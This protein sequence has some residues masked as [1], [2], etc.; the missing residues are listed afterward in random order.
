M[1]PI[2]QMVVVEKRKTYWPHILG[3]ALLWSL[4]MTMD[5]ADQAAQAEERAQD[6]SR[7]MAECLN[8]RWTG[9]TESGAQI[10]CMP[11]ETV[12]QRKS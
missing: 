11:A 12:D 9:R 4:A 2:T 1:T 5:Y 6:M 3:I 7:Q 10:G 8:G